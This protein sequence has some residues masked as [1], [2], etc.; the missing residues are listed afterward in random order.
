MVISFGMAFGIS[1]FTKGPRPVSAEN[2]DAN[3]TQKSADT[4]AGEKNPR[5]AHPIPVEK[6]SGFDDQFKSMNEKQLQSLIYDIRQRMEEIKSK[7]SELETEGQRLQLTRETLRTDIN[8]MSRLR[9][10][11]STT[12]NNIKEREESL[13]DAFSRISETQKANLKRQ[14][15]VY[16]KMNSASAGKIIINM[17]ANQQI[18]DA[19][20]IIYYMTERT[21]ANLL[22][23]IANTEPKVAAALCDKL[24]RTTEEK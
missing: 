3:S 7:E 18:N 22:A 10:E 17:V 24:K 12:L 5:I 13:K 11:L 1:W 15:S 6:D 21:S 16:D 4:P 14:A 2:T 9:I 20:T 19:A 8:E 23:E